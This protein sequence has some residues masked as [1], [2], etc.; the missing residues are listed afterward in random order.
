MARPFCPH[1]TAVCH[2]DK[3]RCWNCDRELTTGEQKTS[4]TSVQ[5]TIHGPW[6][7]WHPDGRVRCAM[8]FVSNIS[9]EPMDGRN[10]QID[11]LACREVQ[12]PAIT[13][14]AGVLPADPNSRRSRE[15]LE[16]PPARRRIPIFW[17]VILAL[18]GI[19]L[20]KDVLLSLGILVFLL[21]IL[22]HEFGHFAAAKLVGIPIEQFRVGIGPVVLRWVLGHTRYELRLIPVLGF[23]QPYRMR[24]TDWAHHEAVRRARRQGLPQPPEPDRGFAIVPWGDGLAH[25]VPAEEQ[26]VTS[27]LVSRPR[28]LVFLLGG[29]S[30]NLLTAFLLIVGQGLA[31]GRGITALREFGEMNVTVVTGLPK[32]L[33]EAFKPSSY[34]NA[35]AGLLVAISETTRSRSDPA[36]W[37]IG[38]LALVNLCVCWFNLLPIAPLDGFKCLGVFIE[39]GLGR[40]LPEKRLWPLTAAGILVVLVLLAATLFG[41][42]RDIILTIF[43]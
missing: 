13:P 27:D 34:T 28:R 20:Y 22:I 4:P 25:V 30:F 7:E 39:M 38:L 17:L 37:N 8:T 5:D 23:V 2:C 36:A 41:M 12:S 31:A 1:C 35:E 42:A 43:R 18:L 21:T 26:R 6:T 11:I 15:P 24:P 3:R 40:D 32:G 29:V 16:V 9:E 14:A 33:L 10:Q 19:A